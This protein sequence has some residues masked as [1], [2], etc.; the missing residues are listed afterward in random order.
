ME[1]LLALSMTRAVYKSYNQRMSE[2]SIIT[3]GKTIQVWQ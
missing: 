3:T 2:K 1:T